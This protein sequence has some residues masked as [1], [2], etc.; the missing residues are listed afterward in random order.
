MG[1]YTDEF[2]ER[3]IKVWQKYSKE[4]LTREDAREICDNTFGVYFMVLQAN[5]QELKEKDKKKKEK[6]K[7][8]NG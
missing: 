1:N 7:A 5:V 6:E 2:L 3:T 4:P 8:A